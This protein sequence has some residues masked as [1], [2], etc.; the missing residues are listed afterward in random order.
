[1]SSDDHLKS[2]D[3]IMS[4]CLGEGD[5]WRNH[6]VILLWYQL[7]AMSDDEPCLWCLV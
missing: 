7:R 4:A 1:M 5:R 2:N 6:E 3:V